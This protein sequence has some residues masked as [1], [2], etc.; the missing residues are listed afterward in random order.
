MKKQF[1]AL[2]LTFLGLTLGLA[3]GFTAFAATAH[4]LS[5]QASKQAAAGHHGQH[6]PAATKTS[7]CE[8]SDITCAKTVTSA[9]APDGKL[10]RL[11][12]G[13]QQMFYSISTDNGQH[14]GPA[15]KVDIGAEKISSRGENRPKLGFDD[16]GNVFIS[17]AKP[18]KGKYTSDVRLTY[19]TDGGQ[20]FSAP[21]TVN[22]DGLKIGHS[23]NEMLVAGDGTVT[24][25]WLDGRER[26][27]Q[28]G[29]EGSALY[30]AEGKLTESG[31]N[32]SNIKLADHTCVC[33]RIAMTNTAN[34]EVAA[35]WRHIY[36]DNIRDHALMTFSADNIPQQPMRASFDLWQLNGCP[37][38][39]PGLS[40]NAQNRYHMVWFNNGSKGKGVFYAYSDD[41][42]KSRSTPLSIGDFQAQASYANVVSFGKTVDLVWTQFNGLAYQ[43]YHQRSQDNGQTFAAPKVISQSD[44]DSDR[45][46]LLKRAGRS[47]VSWQRP[48]NGHQVIAL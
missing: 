8:A 43:L 9:F 46:F 21:Q 19:S 17:W 5:A 32:L 30:M 40:I 16:Q 2:S 38:Q 36:D 22:N 14:F 42:G 24:L 23:F 39:G 11:W 31:I 20:H 28:K 33:C 48:N 34:N 7:A 26:K 6:K 47:Y 13:G 18:L 3:S 35:L 44:A 4:Q 41:G 37:H 27:Q 12:S 15:Q 1:N 25:S 45:P 29:Y 10:W